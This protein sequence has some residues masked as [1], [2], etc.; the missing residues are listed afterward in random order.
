MIWLVGAALAAAPAGLGGWQVVA[1]GPVWVG[2]TR[3]GGDPWCQ[4]RATIDA[5]VGEI[6]AVLRDF[7]GYPRVFP[8][9]GAVR[10]LAAD[11]VYFSL[12]MPFPLADR[13]YVAR[14]ARRVE[15]ETVRFDWE[16]VESAVPRTD[17]VRLAEFA[18]TWTLR[19]E[20]GGT[21]VTY[22]WQADLGGDVPAWA[23][24]RAWATQ[25]NE[26]LSKLAAAVE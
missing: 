23:L 25:G 16:S 8:R 7:A 22:T 10:V 2:C 26:V 11:T 12:A 21:A 5:G 14:F 13:E 15:G 3:Y 6:D 20:G 18:G 9:V 4:A 1:S 19:P 24:P 17:A